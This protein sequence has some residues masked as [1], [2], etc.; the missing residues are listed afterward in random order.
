ML[1]FFTGLY[2]VMDIKSGMVIDTEL[3]HVCQAANSA[4]MEKIGL[5]K[6]LERLVDAD[7]TMRMI[8]T[9]RSTQVKTFC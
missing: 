7:V 6:V 3:V 4:A 5:Q 8:A 1:Q 2:T 9:D